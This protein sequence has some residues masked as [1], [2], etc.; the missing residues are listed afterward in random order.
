MVYTIV[1]TRLNQPKVKGKSQNGRL[2]THALI[3]TSD[4]HYSGRDIF[5]APQQYILEI[6]VSL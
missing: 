6:I 4:S 2:V 1:S 5:C 3:P